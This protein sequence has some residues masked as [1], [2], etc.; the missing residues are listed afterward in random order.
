[1]SKIIDFT[2]SSFIIE[3]RMLDCQLRSILFMDFIFCLDS[4]SIT[5]DRYEFVLENDFLWQEHVHFLAS[6]Q[7]FAHVVHRNFMP[8]MTKK[9][10]KLNTKSEGNTTL[11]KDEK[12]PQTGMN[13]LQNQY[14]TLWII[15][16]GVF[17]LILFV[18]F[19]KV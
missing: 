12:H 16:V 4:I 11:Q 18:S 5:L 8:Y 10:F 14:L 1:M 9:L 3:P 13:W 6:Q 2:Y 19:R 7:N 15:F 17:L